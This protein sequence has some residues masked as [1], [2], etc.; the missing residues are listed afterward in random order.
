MS[1]F[2]FSPEPAELEGEMHGVGRQREGGAGANATC[3]RQFSVVLWCC[4]LLPDYAIIGNH[5]HAR[6]EQR[7]AKSLDTSM[8]LPACLT[9]ALGHL[10]LYLPK[11]REIT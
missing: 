4:C 1:N 6:L 8:R 11:K 10:A 5:F 7:A 2:T 9:W 3:S